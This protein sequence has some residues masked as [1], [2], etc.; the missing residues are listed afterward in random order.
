M[1]TRIEFAGAGHT[2]V[3]YLEFVL[4]NAFGFRAVAFAS[5]RAYVKNETETAKVFSISFTPFASASWL[6]RRLAGWPD[7]SLAAPRAAAAAST[8]TPAVLM[9]KNKKRIS[10]QIYYKAQQVAVV[11]GGFIVVAVVV[12]W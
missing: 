8:Y 12:E 2:C 3:L 9:Y 1:D 7:D 5:W 11:V 6:A 10:K 4:G